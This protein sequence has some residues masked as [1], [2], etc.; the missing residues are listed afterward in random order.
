MISKDLEARNRERRIANADEYLSKV[1]CLFSG[2]SPL[3][4]DLSQVHCRAVPQG[5]VRE[6]SD[7]HAKN[8]EHIEYSGTQHERFNLPSSE[9]CQRVSRCHVGN[10]TSSCKWLKAW[11]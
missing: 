11:S 10:F 9:S 7:I 6:K 2:S 5:Q 4:Y 1:V 3:G 8:S